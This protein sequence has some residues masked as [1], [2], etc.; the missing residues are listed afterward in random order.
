MKPSK[1]N[2]EFDPNAVYIPTHTLRRDDRSGY[3][4][5]HVTRNQETPERRRAKAT[6]VRRIRREID[7]LGGA[8]KLFE[9]E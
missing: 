3:E 4:Q 6:T 9:Q 1:F 7:E 5:T 8:D 2:F